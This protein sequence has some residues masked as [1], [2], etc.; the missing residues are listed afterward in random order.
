MTTLAFS[1]YSGKGVYALL[2]GSGISRSAEIPT[3]W[4]VTLDLVRKV[5]VARGVDCEPDPAGW[6][7][8]EFE[9]EPDYSDLL[10]ALALTP[11]DR[12]NAL[13]AYF[14]ASVAE[15]EDN[16]KAPTAAHKAI[17]RLAAKGYLKVIL[18][19]NF[20]RLIEQALEAEGVN[21]SI[22]S[23]DDMALGATPLAHATC[24]LVK[25]H[26]DYRD[27]RIR[28][29]QAELN[30]YSPVLNRLLDRVFDDYGLI[31]SGWSATWDH[32][33]RNAILRCPNRRYSTFW[34]IRGDVSPEA[35][36]LIR[37]RSAE[38]IPSVSADAF[39]TAVETT[40]DALVAYDQPHPLSVPAAVASL[41]RFLSEDK[42]R[43]N[44]RDLVTD[45]LE[46]QI[47]ALELLPKSGQA[48]VESI[49]DRLQQY[50]ARLTMLM[51]L[52]AT[53]SY[54]GT[55][56]QNE[57]WQ[58]VIVRLGSLGRFSVG[59]NNVYLMLSLWP[60]CLIFYAVAIAAVAGSR[61]DLL[62]KLLQAKTSKPLAF[63]G[64]E[65]R[66]YRQLYPSTVLE[67]SWLTGGRQRTLDTP[68]NDRLATAL[69]EAF[70][71]LMPDD[72]EFEDTIDVFEYIAALYYASSESAK[73]GQLPA[74]VPWGRFVHRNRGWGFSTEEHVT[75]RLAEQCVDQGT[76][77]G[78]IAAGIFSSVD[79]FKRLNNHVKDEFFSKLPAF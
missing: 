32:A 66:L 29:T 54:F 64:S 77:W 44:L 16:K 46:R 6:Y 51:S 15:R 58:N 57:L 5:A 69:R 18:T 7:Q 67:S 70:R 43:I 38:L 63:N 3:G 40:V 8:R 79:D 2:L 10:E 36:D 49:Q 1:V 4:E 28:N 21:P 71:P 25:I 75:T 59:S 65:T 62:A 53:G 41:K 50:E 72:R 42:Y 23:S 55:T 56:A 19:T 9:R 30:A 13:A 73:N 52:A 45:E 22:I 74:W 33:L 20:D 11:A 48:T 12:M 26:G 14:E 37:A 47:S 68:A 27:S 76:S 31:I 17:A 34:S 60:A 61:Y 39:F 24:T 35:R 78:P